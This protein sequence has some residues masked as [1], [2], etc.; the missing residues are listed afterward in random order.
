[1]NILRDSPFKRSQLVKTILWVG[2][3]LSLFYLFYGPRYRPKSTTISYSEFKKLVNKG[4]VVDI[5][6]EDEKIAGNLKEPLSLGSGE[7]G[8][9]V[10]R[11]K[12]ILPS[13]EDPHLL[14]LLEKNK[15]TIKAES[16]ER[17]WA[18][19]LLISLL[20]WLLII[21]FFV[22]SSR[23]FQQRMG[24]AAGGGP[25]GFGKSKAKLYTKSDSDTSFQDVAGLLNVKKELTEIVDFLRNPTHFRNLGGELPKGILLVG[26]PGTGKTLM[27]RAVAGEA[28]VPFYSISG[29]E[30]IEM[31]VGVGASRVRDM[32]SKAKKDAPAII[33]ID[34]IDSIG[35]VR[36]TGLGGGHDE[37]EQTLN[38]I[39]A[40]MDG[41]SPQE[42]VIVMAATNRPDVL[43]PALIRPGRFDRRIT[44]D[45][46]DKKARKQILE[47]HSRDVPLADDVDLETVAAMSVGFSGADLKNLVNEAALYAGR[48][49]KKQV[50]AEDFDLA[51]D[52]IRLGIEREDVVG[53]ADKE[54]IAYH[55]AGHALMARLSPKADPLK[56]VSII[57]RGRALGATEQLPEEDR[58]N[59]SRSYLLDRIAVMLGGRAAEKLVFNDLTSGAGD[60]LKQ[61]T[62]LARR[63][64]CQWGMSNKLGPVTFRQGETHPFL[65]REI[66]EH[67]DFS[68]QTARIIDAEIRQII[69]G[70]EKKAEDMLDDN[71]DKLDTL[72]AALLEK[73]TMENQ[74][75]DDLLN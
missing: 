36:G 64:V 56:K 17:S 30:F 1:M 14:N 75:I 10:K 62:N 60:D 6:V 68:E 31:F 52:K 22:W 42:T 4:S 28:D 25:F 23:K 2:L 34:E 69:R 57:P 18:G 72:A 33:F 37:R 12:T 59:L 3:F 39:L 44:L 74:E 26:P 53:D 54:I 51:L 63:M 58:Y 16:D 5:V 47:I 67:K 38:Q 71:R 29:S 45:R 66:A 46:P 27:A 50:E 24:S 49:E 19:T 73:E 70:Q 43:D 35:R 8:M 41:F 20:P 15:V 40:E 13:F 65:G 7:N 21:G 61:A 11:F 9:K 32:F 55:E 48:K